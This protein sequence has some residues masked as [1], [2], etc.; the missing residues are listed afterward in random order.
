MHVDYAP[1]CAGEPE[2]WFSDLADDIE[3]ASWRC[4]DCRAFVACGAY[5]ELAG[6]AARPLNADGSN[7][8]G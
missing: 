1:P 8:L 6:E 5:A 3:A 4:L 2:L 7:T